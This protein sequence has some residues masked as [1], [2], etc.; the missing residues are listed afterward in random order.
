MARYIIEYTITCNNDLTKEITANSLK[1][2]GEKAE[3]WLHAA[4]DALPDNAELDL[5]EVREAGE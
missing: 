3:A 5:E 2:A 4:E 1:E